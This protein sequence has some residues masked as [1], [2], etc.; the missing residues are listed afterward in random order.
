MDARDQATVSA[1]L[2][3]F[4]AI[5]FTLALGHAYQS[6]DV[7]GAAFGFSVMGFV[8]IKTNAERRS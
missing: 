1:L 8:F 4:G 7:G 2:Y 5:V 3:W 6:A